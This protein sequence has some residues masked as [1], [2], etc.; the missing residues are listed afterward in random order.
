M[1]TTEPSSK[2]Q[3]AAGAIEEE[4]GDSPKRTFNLSQISWLS[5]DGPSRVKEKAA[6]AAALL[7][8]SFPLAP[9]FGLLVQASR[10]VTPIASREDGALDYSTPKYDVYD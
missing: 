1:G 2:R 7:S 9:F 3:L 8:L 4:E 10:A 5:L 6:A